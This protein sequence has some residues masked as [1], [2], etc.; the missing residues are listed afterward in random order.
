M[1]TLGEYI[2]NN[3]KKV[4]VFIFR[5]IDRFTRNGILGYEQL[6]QRLLEQ[7][8]QPVDSYGIIQPSQNTLEHLHVEYPWSRISPSETTEL[9]MAQEGKNEV[10]RILTRMIGSEINLVREGYHVGAPKEGFVN[11]RIFVEGKKKPIQKADP[12]SSQFFIKMYEL[13]ALGTHSDQEIVDQI[14]AM[15]YKSRVRNKWSKRK[16]KLI[17]TTGGMKLSVKRL[18]SYISNTIYCGV[19]KEKWL[20]KVSGVSGDINLE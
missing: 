13:R 9:V 1:I 14:N 20:E 15:G 16:D 19:N 5:V 6:K 10:N 4:D 8:V 18:Q 3:P 7:K 11:E 12:C 2:K 17:G